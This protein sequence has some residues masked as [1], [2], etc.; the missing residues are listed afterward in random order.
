MARIEIVPVRAPDGEVTYH[1]LADDKRSQG[2]TDGEA[3]D[4][5]RSQLAGAEGTTLVIVQSFRADR[6]FD[7]GQQELLAG[8]MARWRRARDTG[9]ELSPEAQ[10]ELDGLIEEEVRA[11]ARRTAALLQDLG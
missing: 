5:L 7:A 11:S 8:L 4:A 1:A 9:E 2:R 10:S 3:L 6:F